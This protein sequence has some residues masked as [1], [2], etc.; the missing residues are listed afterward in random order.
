MAPNYFDNSSWSLGASSECYKVNLNIKHF[1]K[2]FFFQYLKEYQKNKKNVVPPRTRRPRTD[3][4]IENNQPS[5]VYTIPTTR[6]LEIMNPALTQP[7]SENVMHGILKYF[8]FVIYEVLSLNFCYTD[9]PPS[10]DEAVTT[11]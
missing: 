6:Q 1:S 11:R 4:D 7:R 8:F 2:L 5:S 9:L 10:Y 3:N